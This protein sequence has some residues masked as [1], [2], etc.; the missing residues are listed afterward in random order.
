MAGRVSQSGSP[1]LNTSLPPGEWQTYDID[2]RAPRF[3]DKGVKVKPAEL[4]VVHNGELIHDKIEI[5]NIT[6][7]GDGSDP[8]EPG[9]LLLQ[10]HGNQVQNRNIWFVQ[11]DEKGEG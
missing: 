6:P 2:F 11:L 4:S 8:K 3:D 1:K 10:D 9:S 5:G 7:G